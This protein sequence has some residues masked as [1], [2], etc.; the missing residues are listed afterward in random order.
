MV[1]HNLPRIV[2]ALLDAGLPAQTPAAVIASATT[3]QERVLITTLD[4]VAA[5]ARA[6]EFEP[7]AI[8]VI[9]DIVNWRAR[10]L[11]ADAA[12]GRDDLTAN[13]VGEP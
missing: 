3:P 1:M 7:P 11:G 12:A 10:L 2:G 6:Q 5:E 4:K 8:V 13:S 9:G